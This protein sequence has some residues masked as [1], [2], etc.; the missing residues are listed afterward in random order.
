MDMIHGEVTAMTSLDDLKQDLATR[1]SS[2]HV[3]HSLMQQEWRLVGG[4]ADLAGSN[5]LP[6]GHAIEPD[7]YDGSLIHF[8]V[9]EFGMMAMCN[10]L[11]LSGFKPFCATFSY[12][13]RLWPQCDSHGCT[14]VIARDLYH[15]S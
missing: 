11:A 15:D 10:G 7:A 4:S 5:G 8:G 6:N 9:R 1:V 14:D 2:K 3:L 12:L 13:F